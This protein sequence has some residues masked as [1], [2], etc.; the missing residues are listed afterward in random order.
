MPEELCRPST[1]TR[2]VTWTIDGDVLSETFYRTHGFCVTCGTRGTWSS[3][4]SSHRLCTACGTL[5][6]L[7]GQPEPA[8]D[9]W[10]EILQQIRA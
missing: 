10:A 3:D 2:Q 4:D 9:F 8:E 1:N 7:A 6:S 5:L